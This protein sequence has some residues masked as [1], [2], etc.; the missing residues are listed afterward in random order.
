MAAP[1]GRNPRAK[2]I[3][4]FADKNLD[5]RRVTRVVAGGKRFR[6][7][8]TIVIGNRAGKVG[9]GTAKGV[10]VA[11]AVEKARAV[12]KKNMISVAVKNG[13]IAHEVEGK[14]SSARVIIK[15]AT[16]GY[17]LVAGGAVRAVL[18][19]AGVSDATAKILSR[20][21]NKLTNALA[22]MHALAQI[23]KD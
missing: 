13:T 9:V 19:L 15:P 22:T 5:I 21:T 7:R 17:G 4:D 18:S 14:Y 20:T 16:K 6:F 10:D 3:D 23:K 12:A 1:R 8:A 11:G 2:K